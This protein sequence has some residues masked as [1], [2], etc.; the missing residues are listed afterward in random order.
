MSECEK[1]REDIRAGLVAVLG[2]LTYDSGV[3]WDYRTG[4]LAVGQNS[5]PPVKI[6]RAGFVAT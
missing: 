4:A 2:I 6:M 3:S 1:S 5:S